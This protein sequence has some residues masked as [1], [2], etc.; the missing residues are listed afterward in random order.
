MAIFKNPSSGKQYYKFNVGNR[1]VLA[2]AM[3]S[4]EGNNYYVKRDLGTASGIRI[5][6]K[7]ILGNFIELSPVREIN[8]VEYI[9]PTFEGA[10]SIYFSKVPQSNSVTQPIRLI[11]IMRPATEWVSLEDGKVIQNYDPT[12]RVEK[13]EKGVKKY[14]YPAE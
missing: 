14:Y 3:V 11:E 1:Q 13:I 2:E 9:S 4:Y 5:Y 6:E 7:D 8:G 10:K 12:K